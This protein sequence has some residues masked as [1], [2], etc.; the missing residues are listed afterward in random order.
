MS[1]K[2]VKR[3]LYYYNYAIFVLSEFWYPVRQF[4]LK[5]EWGTT[6]NALEVNI[7]SAGVPLGGGSD[8]PL[9]GLR[10]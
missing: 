8:S 9:L 7:L 4:D 5:E 2:F 6:E 10:G 1:T 3:Q